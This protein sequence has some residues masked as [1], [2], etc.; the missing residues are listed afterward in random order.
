MRPAGPLLIVEADRSCTHA[1]ARAFVAR[2]PLPAPLKPAA[3]A[4]F[5]TWVAGQSLDLDDA[6]ALAARA[7]L[8]QVVVQRI[9]GMPLLMLAGLRA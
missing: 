1:D 3:L 5:R 2:M 6:R 9:A 8:Q 4:T 7:P